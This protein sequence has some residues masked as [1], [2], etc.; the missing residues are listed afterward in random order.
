[1]HHLHD[2]LDGQAGVLDVGH[3][4]AALVG[5]GFVGDEAV[6]LGVV[7]ELGAGEGVGDGDLDG[8]AVELLGE[9]DG[10]ADRLAGLAGQAE[11]EVAVD[12]QAELVAVAL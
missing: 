4:V 8:L 2:V 5:H 9:L 1:V 10:V 3:L 12:D 7:E 6:L 11:D